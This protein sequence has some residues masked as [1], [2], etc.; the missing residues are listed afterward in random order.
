[1]RKKTTD[2]A[3]FWSSRVE[4]IS[5]FIHHTLLEKEIKVV[6]MDKA[7]MDYYIRLINFYCQFLLPET[8]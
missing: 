2:S 6:K 3:F 7:T 5:R 1:M 8:G 4:N